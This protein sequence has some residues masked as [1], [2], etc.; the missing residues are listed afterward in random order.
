MPTEAQRRRIQEQRARAAINRAKR[1]QT[2]LSVREFQQSDQFVGRDTPVATGQR[3][4]Q[5]TRQLQ[6]RNITPALAAA[7]QAQESR[8]LH[9]GSTGRTIAAGSPGTIQQQKSRERE[10]LAA[11]M[12]QKQSQREALTQQARVAAG[13]AGGQQRQVTRRFGSG[14]ASQQKMFNFSFEESGDE[15]LNKMRSELAEIQASP[16]FGRRTQ[17]QAELQR[18]IGAREK[19]LFESS[20]YFEQLKISLEGLESD[21]D[22]RMAAERQARQEAKGFSSNLSILRTPAGD[23]ELDRDKIE[24]LVNGTPLASDQRLDRLEEETDEEFAVRK[25]N[26]VKNMERDRISRQFNQQKTQIKEA[27]ASFVDPNTGKV[28]PNAARR[29]AKALRKLASEREFQLGQLEK[30]ADLQLESF[31]RDVRKAKQKSP[32]EL[33]QERSE[34]EIASKAMQLSQ[35]QGIPLTMAIGKAKDMLSFKQEKEE[36]Q[37]DRIDFLNDIEAGTGIDRGNAVG[38]VFNKLRNLTDTEDY[39]REVLGMGEFEVKEQIKQHRLALNPHLTEEDLDREMEAV[40]LA[41]QQTK[42]IRGEIKGI[43]LGSFLDQAEASKT[44]EGFKRM[45]DVAIASG[46]YEGT[47][48]EQLLRARRQAVSG[49]DEPDFE[50]AKFEFGVSKEFEDQSKDFVDTQNAF[51]RINAVARSVSGAGDLALI[52][53]FMKM[54]DPAS[55]VRESEFR[56]AEQAKSWLERTESDGTLVPSVVKTAI[57][58][59][60]PE[61][62]GAFLRPRQREDFLQQSRNIYEAQRE[63]Q[64]GR[65]SQFQRQMDLFGGRPEVLRNLIDQGLEDPAQKEAS[66]L[67]ISN[68]QKFEGFRSQAY[69]DQAGIPTIGYGFTSVG[70]NPVKMGDTISQEEAAQELERQLP[71][72]ESWKSEVT[73]Q[74]NPEQQA[75]LTSFT[76]NLGQNIWSTKG[77]KRLAQLINDG[78]FKRAVELFRKFNKFRSPQ[79]GQLTPS[80]GLSQ[81]REQ[82]SLPFTNNA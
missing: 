43:A 55:V 45:L 4:A 34:M 69:K 46:N 24:R 21:D 58:K 72:Y 77:G 30:R 75:A 32:L 54:L 49:E 56:S 36:T 22:I 57:Q 5:P 47:M 28:N 14:T 60:D 66:D 7:Q 3:R 71:I 13:I 76:Y 50:Q 23:I 65:Q 61:M 29:Q 10:L 17:Q 68:I 18:Q 25:M 6:S 62:Q 11:G 26:S 67:S 38:I 2:D 35:N 19:E 27:F 41:E 74:L 40:S 64:V 33:L 79:T 78:D 37:Q 73:T 52:F 48:E 80:R 8:P 81:R 20:P 15:Q 82:E 39:M 44:E 51:R 70:G 16:F 42:F 1:S 12:G 31:I 59:A 53:N 9:F 63:A